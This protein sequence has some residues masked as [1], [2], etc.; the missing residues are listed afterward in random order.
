[1]TRSVRH[2][3]QFLAHSAEGP[4]VPVMI[5]RVTNNVRIDLVDLHLLSLARINREIAQIMATT[6]HTE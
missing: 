2:R 5:R 3:F 1:M 6:Q 4:L